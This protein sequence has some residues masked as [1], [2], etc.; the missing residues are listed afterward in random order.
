M[1]HKVKKETTHSS[2]SGDLE[3]HI[4]LENLLLIWISSKTM[5]HLNFNH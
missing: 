2:P 5:L 3:D 4:H 1:D